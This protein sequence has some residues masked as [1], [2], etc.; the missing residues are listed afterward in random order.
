MATTVSS[1]SAALSAEG[2]RKVF[3]DLSKTQIVGTGDTT[4]DAFLAKRANQTIWVQ[5]IVVY[6]TTS[7]A[8]SLSFQDDASTPLV[9]AK[10]PATPAVDTRWDF[11][12]GDRGVPLT[13]NKDL[14]IS[15][16]GA[17]LAANIQVYAYQVHS[18]TI[19]STA[20]SASQ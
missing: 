3:R 7:S 10:V 18:S 1:T 5:R 19:D 11:D 12:F 17:G 2:Y 15:I 13:E 9:I 6:I 20:G 4:V 8:Q 16:S 14:D